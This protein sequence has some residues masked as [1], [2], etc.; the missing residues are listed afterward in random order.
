VVERLF[1]WINR[2]RQLAKDFVESIESVEA[3]LDA[4]SSA[5]LMRQLAR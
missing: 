1:A 4:S 2:N 5:L 3:F